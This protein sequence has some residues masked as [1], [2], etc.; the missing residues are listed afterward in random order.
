[1]KVKES[2][3]EEE[4]GARSAVVNKNDAPFLQLD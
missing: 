1:M 4:K 3:K 2:R